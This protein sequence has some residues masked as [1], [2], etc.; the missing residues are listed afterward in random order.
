MGKGQWHPH[1][2]CYSLIAFNKRKRNLLALAHLVTALC[3]SVFCIGCVC[4]YVVVI[5]EPHT[6]IMQQTHNQGSNQVR[7]SQGLKSKSC[8]GSFGPLML[9]FWGPSQSFKGQSFILFAN[10]IIL[11]AH[12]QFCRP[13]A[14]GPTLFLTPGWSHFGQ[15]QN[16]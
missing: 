8:K 15:L 10:G 9:Y 2:C 13:L 3:M 12:M 4:H 11:R 1:I 6:K 5:H 7:W 14:R 16:T